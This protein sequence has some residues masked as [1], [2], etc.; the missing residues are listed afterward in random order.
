[1]PVV[2]QRFSAA[3]NAFGFALFNQISQ[4]EKGKNLF[5][6]PSSVAVA[7]AM[8]YNG[9]QGDTQKAMEQ[10]LR[11]S[12]MSMDDV[13]KSAN[14]WLQAL[15]TPTPK[16]DISIANSIW[17]RQ[18]IQLLPQFSDRVKAS[19]GAEVNTLDF[20]KP[21]AAGTIN[22][23]V[24]SQTKGKIK[25]IVASPIA[26]DKILF[27]VNALYFKGQWST[28]FDPKQTRD[29]PFT[30]LNGAKVNVP[31]MS[32]I[33]DFET[34]NGDG[35]QV[36]RLPYGDGRF[37]MYIFVPTA[38]QD[39]YGIAK[40]LTP[41]T[42]QSWSSGFGK[43]NVPLM[44]PKFTF[45]YDITLND[46]LKSLG[47]AQAFNAGS[48]DFSGMVNTGSQRA[49]ISEVKHKTFVVVNE[50][51]TEAAAA[52]SVGVNVT[53]MPVPFAVDQPFLTL[54]RDNVTNTV[55]FMGLVLDPR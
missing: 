49:Y 53:S 25:D 54:V 22:A 13:N 12:G 46:A 43:R 3:Q 17:A 48:A 23:W 40:Q 38:N 55:L 44:M 24:N 50:E 6:S 33:G 39:A 30:L 2:D 8:T 10:T 5:V 31:T 21:D 7:L 1:M 20:S 9:A 16:V 41:E 36:V 35:Y 45:A 11:L 27:L 32:R 52:T 29:A 28:Q 18:G 4:T 37:S 47:M 34:K 42:W 19:Y 26:D 14:A 51:G 15:K